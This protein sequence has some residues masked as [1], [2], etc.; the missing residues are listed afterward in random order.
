MVVFYIAS[1]NDAAYFD[2]CNRCGRSRSAFALLSNIAVATYEV[3]S[4]IDI[5]DLPRKAERPR[6]HH[7]RYGQ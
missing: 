4:K 6:R 7:G 3:C 1:S 5:P 2:E